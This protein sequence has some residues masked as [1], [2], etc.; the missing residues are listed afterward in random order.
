MAHYIPQDVKLREIYREGWID[1][2]K[3][4]KKDPYEDPSL[5]VEVR[6]EDLL[7]RMTVE[8]KLMELRS[9]FRPEDN[10]GNISVALRPLPP[11]EAALK[12]NEIQRRAVEETRLGIPRIIHDE[13]LHGL[14][15]RSSTVFP[16]AIGLAATWDPELM[17]KV[18]KIIGRE[19]R[20]RGVTQCLSPVVN[21]T[22]DS[23][24]G[25]TEETYGE[26]PH[27]ASV[28]AEAYVKG[29]WENRVIATPK[30]FVLNFVGDGGRDSA[31]VHFSERILRETELRPFQA[32]IRAGALSLMAAYNSLDGIPCSSNRWLLT[33][34]LRWELGF[35]GFVVSDYGS[36]T[37]I[38]ERHR[39]TSSPEE[40][41]KAA[42]EA[43]LEVE[44]PGVN[45]Y[46]DPLLR[47]VKEGLIPQEV[48]D[49][50]VRRVLRAK[51][52]IGIFDELYVNPEDAERVPEE[53]KSLA[54]EAARKSVVLLKNEGLLPL[55]RVKSVAVLGPLSDEVR[56]GGYSGTPR[57][58][59]SPLQGIKAVSEPRGIT[60]YHA[61]ACPADLD[62]D[63]AI[64]N[65]YFTPP[66]GVEPGRNGL[67]G[68]YFSNP[69]LAGNPLG[70]RLQAPWEGYMR[71]DWGYDPPY[72]GLPRDSYSVRLRGSIT[73][74]ETGRYRFRLFASGGGARLWVDGKL[75]IDSWD[76]PSDLPRE[77][78]IELEG[79]KAHDLRLEYRKVGHGYAYLKV[80][81]DLEDPAS[82]K[83]AVEIASKVDAVVI[84]AGVM[85]GEQRDRASLRLPRLQ[86]RLIQE[87]LKV[88][89]RVV[90]VLETG[91]PVVGEWIVQVPA[92]VQAWYPGQEGGTAIAEVLF[93]LVNPSGKLPLT[94]PRHEG[95]EP[96]YY[97][98][99]PSG[100]VYDY[101]NM[102]STPLFPFGHGLSYTKFKYGD[103]NVT[104]EGLNWRISLQVQNTGAV[105][106][107]EVVQLYVRDEVSTLSRPLLELKGFK[108]IKLR[109]GESTKVEFTL[110]PD[111]LAMFDS[112]MRRVVEPGEFR[113]LVGSS[114]SDLRLMTHISLRQEI[115]A[116]PSLVVEVPARGSVREGQALHLKVRVRNGGPISD[117]TP[118]TLYLDDQ[119]LEAHRLFLG[120]GEEREV[121]F[122]VRPGEA[123][124]HAISIGTPE[125]KAV[126][127]VE[128]E[129]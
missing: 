124:S 37:G 98:F 19:A 81:W 49:E 112:N 29:L 126:V 66:P 70:S 104:Q 73:P 7:S 105:E 80:G 68:E 129:K 84:F 38:L 90:V 64:P 52:E 69:D 116:E 63:L 24:A 23:R 74:P 28:M 3:D 127:V 8:E 91:S 76:S 47:A 102:P 11:R 16:Q 114:A 1:L 27:L 36:V 85:E 107:E 88:N 77:G 122:T 101:V 4:G 79:G 14:M 115:R 108:R 58:A 71:F 21:L 109:P 57:S 26:D 83:E 82:L 17:L 55:D 93:G 95:Q 59:V 92:I 89:P 87:V 128:V 99:K 41:A 30:H 40:T 72:P 120:P 61:K 22:W 43:G 39:T 62:L 10:V 103:L 111:D 34:V 75:V 110:T 100:R 54:L 51:F 35:K 50:A 56:L 46:G 48:V 32:S 45:I 53:A 121:V 78:V 12:A 2:S 9:S 18:S 33:E 20:S 117:L 94:W 86:E 67:L 106:G 13:C 65:K 125:P 15:A 97:N 5:P 119:G 44:L 96:L 60:V 25:R 42:L 6:V 123:G 31:E 113:V 118:L